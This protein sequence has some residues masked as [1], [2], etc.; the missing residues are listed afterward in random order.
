M[1]KVGGVKLIKPKKVER[2]EKSYSPY[3]GKFIYEPLEKGYGITLGNALRR[4]LL[5]SIPGAAITSVKIDGVAH[6]FSTIS[7]VLEDV[8]DIVLNLKQVR[9][10]LHANPPRTIKIEKEG[11]AEVKAG[12]II[13]DGSVDIVNPEQHIATLTSKEAK[14]IME[15]TVNLGR[16]YVPAERNKQEGQPLGTVPIDAIF[17]PIRKVNFTVRNARVGQMTDYDK[18][19]LEVWTDGTI[20]SEKAISLAAK[21]LRDQL[22]IFL[23]EEEEETLSELPEEKEEEEIPKEVF[24][25]NIDELELSVRALNCLKNSHIHLI[26]ELVQKTE[27]ELL[28]TRNFGRKSLNEIKNVLH[29]MGLSLGMELQDFPDPEILKKIEG[30]QV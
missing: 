1:S 4:V 7:G 30:G 9:L 6:E 11:E 5:S 19:I 29:Q 2:D 18:L 21:I 22:D 16:G 23:I 13:T 10:K 27:D 3:Y 26:G 12:D 15:M 24:Y 20:T 8:T 14:L 28:K 25:K 17:S